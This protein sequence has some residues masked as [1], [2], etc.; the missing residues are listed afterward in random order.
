MRI[1]KPLLAGLALVA[2]SWPASAGVESTVHKAAAGASSV[3]G[4]VERAVKRGV[5]AGIHGVERGTKAAG[6]AV[7][8]G[9]K[10]IGI[11]AGASVPAA[12]PNGD[13]PRR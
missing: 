4:K 1:A 9:A 7:N 3:A 6:R 8:T 2:W 10:K 12:A 11:P 5:D 13:M